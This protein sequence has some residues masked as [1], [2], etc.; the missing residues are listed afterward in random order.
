[1]QQ[2]LEEIGARIAAARQVRG[3]TQGGLAAQVGVSRSAV[4]QWETGRAGQVTANLA[5][6]AAV[7]DVGI[8]HLMRG[9]TSACPTRSG[10]RRGDGDAAAV[11]RLCPEADG[12]SCFARR[13]GWRRIRDRTAENGAKK[14]IMIPVTDSIMLDPR[15]IEEQFIL[16]GGPGG[17][18]VNKVATAV[19]LRFSLNG[20]SDLPE[21][22]A[23]VS[24]GSPGGV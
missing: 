17:Q 4:A 2:Q 11:S 16:A 10:Q 18:N 20:V 9:R 13:A 6:I 8:E 19:Q 7:L 24:P 5:R 15:D 23:S 1:M 22:C 3:W 12:R 14:A 21:D